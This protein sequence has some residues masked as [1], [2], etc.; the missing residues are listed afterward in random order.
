MPLPPASAAGVSPVLLEVLPANLMTLAGGMTATTLP[1]T[2]QEDSIVMEAV[3]LSSE[4]PFTRWSDLAA[5]LPGRVGKQVRDRWTNQLNPHIIH[6]PFR[7]D[8]DLVLWEGHTKLG[9]R[10]VELSTTLFQSTRSENQIKNR[11]YSASFQKFIADEFGPTAYEDPATARRNSNSST[12]SSS[13]SSAAIVDS[14]A[15]L[16]DRTLLLGESTVVVP[17]PLPPASAVPAGVPLL[18]EVLLADP[19][20]IAGSRTTT[21]NT[22]ATVAEAEDE[23]GTVEAAAAAAAAMNAMHHTTEET[24]HTLGVENNNNTEEDGVPSPYRHV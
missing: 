24:M 23:A 10:W 6:R 20:T 13:S 2:E 4:Q 17:M 15:S 11:W 14:K 8:E 21:T 9:K 22:Y 19:S 12:N 5:Q 1:W 16:N 7:R 18:P 3:T